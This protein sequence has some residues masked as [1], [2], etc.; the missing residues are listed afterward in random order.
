M[1]YL[2]SKARDLVTADRIYAGT[3]YKDWPSIDR[4]TAARRETI[5]LKSSRKSDQ[6]GGFLRTRSWLFST[7]KANTADS[8][9][10]PLIKN[11]IWT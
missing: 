6:Y 9:Q 2:F 4:T 5:I 7:L 3:G 8:T 11:D 10:T 1:H